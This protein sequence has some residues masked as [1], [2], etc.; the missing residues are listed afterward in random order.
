MAARSPFARLSGHSSVRL[1]AFVFLVVVV[2]TGALS[3]KTVDSVDSEVLIH[4]RGLKKQYKEHKRRSGRSHSD[5]PCLFCKHNCE[6]FFFLSMSSVL[7]SAEVEHSKT[8]ILQVVSLHCH[9]Q[10]H[11]F[12]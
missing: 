8:E 7:T 10:S 5:S 3:S 4:S 6:L 9:K 11:C 12:C 2:G 1:F